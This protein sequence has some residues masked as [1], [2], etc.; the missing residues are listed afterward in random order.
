M[1]HSRR[2]LICVPNEATWSLDLPI[3]G[4][5][6]LGFTG[7]CS[8]V[9]HCR[10]LRITDVPLYSRTCTVQERNPGMRE[11][12]FVASSQSSHLCA[13][14]SLCL[15]KSLTSKPLLRTHTFW[16]YPLSISHYDEVRVLTM[17]SDVST[18]VCWD[19]KTLLFVYVQSENQCACYVDLT[20]ISKMQV[21][22]QCCARVQSWECPWGWWVHTF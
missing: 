12:F 20:T 9:P 7:K 10:N 8:N 21:P 19:H 2:T 18:H 17:E 16:C 13:R 4:Y 14:I 15:L 22:Q 11:V 6:V 1:N 5:L 3:L